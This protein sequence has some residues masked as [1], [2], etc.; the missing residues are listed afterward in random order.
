MRIACWSAKSIL[1]Q[2]ERLQSSHDVPF[3]IPWSLFSPGVVPGCFESLPTVLQSSKEDHQGKL[4]PDFWLVPYYILSLLSPRFT[5]VHPAIMLLASPLLA[6]TVTLFTMSYALVV[7]PSHTMSI[8]GFSSVYTVPD[9][10]E[11]TQAARGTINNNLGI[12]QGIPNNAYQDPCGPT[13]QDRVTAGGNTRSTCHKNVSVSHL[14]QPNYYGVRCQNDKTGY[15]LNQTTCLDAMVSMCFQISG[16]QG[17]AYQ[18]NDKWI[19]STCEHNC[20]FGYWLPSQGAPAPSFQRCYEQIVAP[21]D[22]A[23]QEAGWNVGSVN[24]RELPV[25]G[26]IAVSADVSYPSYVMVA[27]GSYWGVNAKDEVAA[28]DCKAQNGLVYD[29]EVVA[30]G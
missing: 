2:P 23:C 9:S 13:P 21:M 3:G 14:D 19:W 30:G 29:C 28:S 6:L 24:L 10:P 12:S 22:E 5:Y 7:D 17:S 27:Q 8:H 16:M 20:T 4:R 25:V 1:P 11:A 26:G 15:V 18:P